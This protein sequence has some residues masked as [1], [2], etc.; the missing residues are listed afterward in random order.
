VRAAQ[1]GALSFHKW[2]RAE[3]KPLKEFL[4]AIVQMARGET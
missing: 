1:S 4:A 3:I 2:M